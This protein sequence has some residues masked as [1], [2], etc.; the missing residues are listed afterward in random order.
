MN[1]KVLAEKFGKVDNLEKLVEDLRLAE[2][3]AA[4]FE[5]LKKHGVQIDPNE[6]KGLIPPDGELSADDLE[7]VAGGCGCGWG[8][9]IVYWLINTIFRFNMSCH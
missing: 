7:D 5:I 1:E 4:V 8:R 6:L 9:Q 3:D 2:D